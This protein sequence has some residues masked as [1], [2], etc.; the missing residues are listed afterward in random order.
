MAPIPTLILAAA[1]LAPA[2]S[3]QAT[4]AAAPISAPRGMGAGPG[5][6][7]IRSRVLPSPGLTVI[8]YPLDNSLI[9][10]DPSPAVERLVDHVRVVEV[11]LPGGQLVVTLRRAAPEAARRGALA[12]SPAGGARALDACALCL[13]GARRWLA[14]V[15]DLLGCVE[16]DPCRLF[17][18]LLEPPATPG[19]PRVDTEPAPPGLDPPPAGP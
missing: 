9:V 10:R 12:L 7:A 11:P 6:P 14:Q 15:S 5:T 16:L 18:L 13:A 3:S 1:A 4:L 17:D 8:G 19:P 2:L